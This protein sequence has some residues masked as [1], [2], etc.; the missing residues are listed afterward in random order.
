MAPDLKRTQNRDELALPASAAAHWILKSQ[1]APEIPSANTRETEVRHSAGAA[2]QGHSTLQI[3]EKQEGI[4]AF[5]G[6]ALQAILTES[7]NCAYEGWMPAK[8]QRQP[9]AKPKKAT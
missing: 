1:Q 3:W 5:V 2:T 9:A 6:A 7:H 4:A 8:P